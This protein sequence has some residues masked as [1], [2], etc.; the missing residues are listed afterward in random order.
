M[1][2]DTT[3][4]TSIY[5]S[6]STATKVTL[7][8]QWN[9]QRLR[10]ADYANVV[11]QTITALVQTSASLIDN[12]ENR[13]EQASQAAAQLAE[14]ARQADAQL[15]QQATLEANR[16]TSQEGIATA[17]RAENARQ[18][19]LQRTQQATLEANKITSQETMEANRLAEQ[20]SQTTADRAEKVREFDASLTQDA[21]VKT[22]QA[23]L[24]T[25]QSATELKKALLTVR[26][27]TMYDDNLRVE[28]G[29]MLTNVVGMYGVGGTVLPTGLE[30]QMINAVDAVTPV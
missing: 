21:P 20:S 14:N 25:N 6:L 12:E 26:Q 16:I 19:D 13:T 8:E 23:T 10:G 15:V 28:E 29:K 17:D 11:A 24:I 9:D 1:A 2:V 30:T 18:A 4:L 27:T 7:D 5:T 3:Q 22:A